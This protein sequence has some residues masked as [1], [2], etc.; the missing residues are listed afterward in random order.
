MAPKLSP[1]MPPCGGLSPNSRRGSILS[2]IALMPLGMKNPRLSLTAMQCDIPMSYSFHASKPHSK[3]FGL[4]IMS[5]QERAGAAGRPSRDPQTPPLALPQ[6]LYAFGCVASLEI[7]FFHTYA[8]SKGVRG[9]TDGMDGL[10]PVFLRNQGPFLRVLAN[11]EH[12]LVWGFLSSVR[13]LQDTHF[14]CSAC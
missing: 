8:P 13:L 14:L 12:V 7:I 5:F 11:K 6:A 9:V 3:N 4:D 10:G 1:C 2:E